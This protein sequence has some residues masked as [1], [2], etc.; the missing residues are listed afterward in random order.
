MRR[1]AGKGATGEVTVT[2]R[3]NGQALVLES[4]ERQPIG[5]RIVVV[6]AFTEPSSFQ[7]W[8]AE[9]PLRHEDPNVHHLVRRHAEELWQSRV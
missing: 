5:I 2:L 6:T 8:S 9:D 1:V 4:E 7:D 3:Q